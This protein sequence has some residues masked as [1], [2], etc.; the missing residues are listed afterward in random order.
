MHRL[1]TMLVVLAA[2]A[3]SGG[4]G[5]ALAGGFLPLPPAQQTLDQTQTVDNSTSQGNDATAVAVTALSGDNVQVGLVNEAGD[6]SA[7]SDAS[8]SQENEN[9]TAQQAS[10]QASQQQNGGSRDSSGQ[11]QDASQSQTVD[12]STEQTNTADAVSATVLSGNNV[13]VGLVNEAGDQSAG[14]DAS[15]SQE[16]ENA[17]AQQASQQASQE[18]TGG[19]SCCHGSTGQEQ[20]ASQSQTVDNST[21]QENKATAL[22]VTALSGNNVQAGGLNKAGDQTATSTARP[23]QENENVTSQRADQRASQEQ[24]GG[25]SCCHGSTGQEQDASQSQT[26][27]NSTRQENKATALAVTALSGNN[28]QAAALNKAGDQTATSTARPTQENENVT[29]QRADQR[30]SQEQNDGC[31]DGCRAGHEHAH[32]HGHGHDPSP[33]TH[34]HAHA[35]GHEPCPPRHEPKPCPPRHEPKPC[36]PEHEHEPCPP[37]HEPKPCPPRPCRDHAQRRHDGGSGQSLEQNQT[38]SNETAQTNET[39]ASSLTLLSG[40]NVQLGLRNCAGD[41]TASSDA[42]PRQRNVNGTFQSAR[43]GAWQGQGALLS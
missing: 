8:P 34:E 19:D 10:Q 2:L 1:T 15:P 35:H 32:T 28:V 3:M 7:G 13:Q 16:N 27:D 11:E 29:S 31:G 24:T 25:D 37:R 14:S 21:R 5:S 12:N 20:D 38:L 40:N 4:A 42:S 9:A 33:P 39:R 36:P 26:V 6:Q 23:T 43:Q 41:Q 17:T 30:A 18:Q 22:A